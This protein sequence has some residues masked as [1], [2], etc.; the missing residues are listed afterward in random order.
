MELG[1]RC[2]VCRAKF[3]RTA[4]CSRCGA[5]LTPLMTLAVRAWQARQAARRALLTGDIETAARRA[6][7]AQD[8]QATEPGR[9][10]VLLSRWARAHH[11]G[12]RPLS[13]DGC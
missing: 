5:D 10:L 4:T 6:A 7:E 1:L 12:R 9:R 11:S 8:L 13:T 2:P 3:R